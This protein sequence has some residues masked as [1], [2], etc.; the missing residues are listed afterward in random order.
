[1][2]QM[3]ETQCYNPEGRDFLS[4]VRTADD[5]MKIL[6]GLLPKRIQNRHRL[7]TLLGNILS[8][9]VQRNELLYS[10]ECLFTDYATQCPQCLYRWA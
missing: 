1:V 5:T 2:A 6:I 10:S 8:K 3:D 4:C 9:Y 7:A